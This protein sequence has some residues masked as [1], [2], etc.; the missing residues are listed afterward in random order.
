[1]AKLFSGLFTAEPKTI[2]GFIAETIGEA[3]LARLRPGRRDLPGYRFV[4]IYQ[5]TDWF[6]T[7]RGLLV[8]IQSEHG[9]SDLNTLLHDKTG[10]WVWR[11]L[12]R[13]KTLSWIVDADREQHFPVDQFWISGKRNQPDSQLIVRVSYNQFGHQTV[14][15]A[16]SPNA[17]LVADAMQAIL[18]RGVS[19]SIYRNKVLELAFT[20]GVRDEYGDV[21]KQEQLRVLIKRFEPVAEADIIIDESVRGALVRN[22]IDLHNRRDVL[23]AN[24]VPIRR[25]V[26]LYGPPGTGKTFACR[27]LFASLP[28]VTRIAVAGTAL[29]QVTQIF[30]LARMFQPS[31]VLFEDVD[32]V[33]A[34]REINAYSPAL[35]ELLDQMDGLRPYED[36]GFVLTTNSI[37]RME[38]AIKDRPGR[39]AQCIY[40]GPPNPALRRRY[41]ARYL[42][43]Y[44]IG[45][46]D[47]D[48]LVDMSEDATQAFLKEWVHHSVQIATERIATPDEAIR[49]TSE[50]FRAAMDEMTRFS[51]GST[52][53]IIGFLR[54]ARHD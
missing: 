35:G 18:K 38:A 51:E 53:R 6:S 23:K 16:A 10:K 52:G 54:P 24:G 28:E 12:R 15:E 19:H 29:G 39:V 34:S 25:G 45:D 13:S 44:D 27:Y 17:E 11:N 1:M 26:L 33:F 50:D 3:T 48:V 37:E 47:L 49:L 21:E 41:L 8:T 43:R 9:N 14:L 36:I 31:L 30:S 20:P 42:E 4:D 7:E 5:A 46:V 32:L 2:R 40:F 22:V